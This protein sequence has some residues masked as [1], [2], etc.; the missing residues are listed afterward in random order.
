MVFRSFAVFPDMIVVPVMGMLL[1]TR[2][3]KKKQMR[4]Y[5]PKMTS[6]PVSQHISWE[7]FLCRNCQII[8]IY[9]LVYISVDIT[10]LL[11]IGHSSVKTILYII[12]KL[13]QFVLALFGTVLILLGGLTP[14]TRWIG[15]PKK[16]CKFVSTYQY[17]ISSISSFLNFLTNVCEF[18]T[19]KVKRD[20]VPPLAVCVLNCPKL[21]GESLHRN[22]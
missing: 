16:Y 21:C 19:L 14:Q 4:I 8:V 15:N 22:Q 5:P 2:H 3:I 11:Q 17:R 18:Q 6:F 1:T 10:P 7:D 9:K 12:V 13:V 20:A